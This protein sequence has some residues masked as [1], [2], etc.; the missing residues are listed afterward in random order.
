MIGVEFVI[1][2]M[3]DGKTDSLTVE[4]MK[5]AKPEG[6]VSYY[7][8]DYTLMNAGIYKYSFRMYPKNSDLP[9]RQ[10]FAYVRWF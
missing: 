4:E 5:E 1:N 10:D 7:E 9:H 8:L 3:T 6:T 2:T